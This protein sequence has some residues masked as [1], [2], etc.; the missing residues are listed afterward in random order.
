MQDNKIARDG[1]TLADMQREVI[2]IAR[3]LGIDTQE[4]EKAETGQK[5]GNAITG[6]VATHLPILSGIQELGQNK[7]HEKNTQTIQAMREVMEQ[8]S[9]KTGIPLDLSD[10]DKRDAKG[11]FI[12]GAATFLASQGG[13]VSNHLAVQNMLSA[14]PSMA[15]AGGSVAGRAIMSAQQNFQEGDIVHN[16]HDT[17][18]LEAALQDIR[19]QMRGQIQGGQSAGGVTYQQVESATVEGPSQGNVRER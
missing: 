17:V 2:G 14:D 13:G 11:G 15:K 3:E 8:I 9:D 19:S 5:K 18:K 16:H 12:K 10:I 1:E 4:L 6:F 7:E